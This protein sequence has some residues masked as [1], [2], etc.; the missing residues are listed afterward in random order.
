M[1]ELK[2]KA[3]EPPKPKKQKLATPA[4]VQPSRESRTKTS[5]AQGTSVPQ[6]EMLNYPI[7]QTPDTGFMGR[8]YQGNAAGDNCFVQDGS[9]TFT[10]DAVDG[11]IMEWTGYSSPD[12]TNSDQHPASPDTPISS[13]ECINQE[14]T[15]PSDCSTMVQSSGRALINPC[16][17]DLMP[18]QLEEFPPLPIEQQFGDNSDKSDSLPDC[19]PRAAPVGEAPRVGQQGGEDMDHDEHH[20]PY[21][22]KSCKAPNSIS[23][24]SG[25]PAILQHFPYEDPTFRFPAEMAPNSAME[26]HSSKITHP[27]IS[28]SSSF[29]TEVGNTPGQTT[30]RLHKVDN[31]FTKSHSGDISIL[32]LNCTEQDPVDMNGSSNG[33]N[34]LEGAPIA[35]PLSENHTSDHLAEVSTNFTSEEYTQDSDCPVSPDY[36]TSQSGPEPTQTRKRPTPANSCGSRSNGTS[37]FKRPR[38]S[39]L[40]NQSILRN[41]TSDRVLRS[42]PSRTKLHSGKSAFDGANRQA[43]RSPRASRLPLTVRPR[44]SVSKEHRANEL[45]TPNNYR[46]QDSSTYKSP[47]QSESS[48]GQKV[49]YSAHRAPVAHNAPYQMHCNLAKNESDRPVWMPA[50]PNS[51]ANSRPLAMQCDTCGFSAE[52]ILRLSDYVQDRLQEGGDNMSTIQLFL[53]FIR[54]YAAQRRTYEKPDI[55]CNHA[56]DGRVHGYTSD[57]DHVSTSGTNEHDR[58]NNA[59]DTESSDEDSDNSSSCRS[60]SPNSGVIMSKKRR[61]EPLEEARLR[62]WVIEKKEWSW[63][64]KKLKRSPGAVSQHWGFMS[65]QDVE[66]AEA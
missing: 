57:S 12:N 26:K 22:I 40:P 24:P 15:S 43:R 50:K 46:R 38:H 32:S 58:G 5:W 23:G 44:N 53:G 13:P 33:G 49:N 41:N 65:K 37:R 27:T 60:E 7:N 21:A 8:L 34:S 1:S 10:G 9:E 18:A 20:E 4:P 3:W 2:F 11:T 66:N 62:A 30:K 6:I 14:A 55:A 17:P 45:S 59:S 48:T 25:A 42:L 16:P 36:T 28:S 39:T 19:R 54:D 35:S 64:A 51:F 61:W 63:I 47:V 52:Q 56:H 31:S 29:T